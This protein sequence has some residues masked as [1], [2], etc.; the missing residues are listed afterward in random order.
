MNGRIHFLITIIFSLLLLSSCITE[1]QIEKREQKEQTSS[2]SAPESEPGEPNEPD[3]IKTENTDE[4]PAEKKAKPEKELPSPVNSEKIPEPDEP[5][6]VAIKQDKTKLTEPAPPN[7]PAE[8]SPADIPAEPCEPNTRTEPVQTE[9]PNQPDK[10][11]TREK[12]VKNKEKT[13]QKEPEPGE[14][15][16]GTEFHKQF[17]GLLKEYVREDG[18][19]Y[20][21]L[22]RR[23]KAELTYL[24]SEFNEVTREEYESWKKEDKIAF[25]INAYNI[26]MLKI[27]T[28]HYPIEASRWLAPFW[29]AYSIR[30]IDK[31]WSKY[32]FMVLDEQFNLHEIENEIFGKQFK[33]PR[34]Y[35]AIY[36]ASVSSPPLRNEPYYGYKLDEQLND[37]VRKFL[38]SPEGLKIDRSNNTVYISAIF[39]PNWRGK[40][41]LEKY[42]T[43]KKFKDKASISRA[44]LNFICNYIPESDKQFLQVGN[45]NLE[46]LKYSWTVNA[47]SV[48]K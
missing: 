6:T 14:E 30:H 25:W 21:D 42:G 41:F 40:R 24:L 37:Q 48:N 32:K 19:V 28:D 9:E 31:I 46:Y 44:I 47:V 20:Y 45:Y 15:W 26:K 1:Q 12:T 11:A 7:K 2:P 23:N 35:F 34:I 16:A 5:N 13:H 4:K 17:A 10:P 36:Q 18:M 39:E 8:P 29:G 33:N 22:L 27:I 38:N 3:T 43:E